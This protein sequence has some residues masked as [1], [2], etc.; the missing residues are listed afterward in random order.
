MHSLYYAD[1]LGSLRDLFGFHDLSLEPDALIAGSARYPILDDVIIL[2]DP[3][4]YTEGVRQRLGGAAHEY[5]KGQPTPSEAT[6]FTFGAEW[7]AYSSVLLE[8]E[9]QFRDYFDLVDLP[10][11]VDSRVCDLGCG[12]G[13]WSYF[14]RDRCREL[15]LVDYSDAIFVARNNLRDTPSSLFFMGDLKALPFRNDFCKLLVCLGVLH[16][17]STPCLE[18]TRQLKR[19]AP[20][21][22]IS[23][24]Y[25]LDNRPFYFRLL[26]RL[27]TGLRLSLC[28]LRGRRARTMTA[29]VL[30][31]SLYLPLIGLGRALTSVGL[32]SYVPL[33][34]SY[35]DSLQRLEQ[36]VYD[37]FFT[38]IEQR[39]TRAQILELQD[40][41]SRVNCPGTFPYYHFLCTR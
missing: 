28:R 35:H 36:D 38:P 25:A 12:N 14:L 39:V 21:L 19:F 33:Y 9:R 30:M 2:C 40:T 37:R 23:L 11:L 31:F 29:K 1:K 7:T 6:R 26:L 3:S 32:S 41:F 17:L 13:R 5:R 4:D 24:Y 22:L 34:D 20:L 15:V 27:V 18:E 10:T 8:H 16:H